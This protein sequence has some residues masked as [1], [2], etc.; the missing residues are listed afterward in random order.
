VTTPSQ[1]FVYEYDPA[2]SW[3]FHVELIGV[4]KDE[5]PRITYPHCMRR[6]GIGPAQY[7]LHAILPDKL[8][9][10]EEQYDLGA[11]EMAEGF[12]SEGEEGADAGEGDI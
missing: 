10:E 6:E 2:K 8:M 7:D 9:E 3:T 12:S 4:S 5:N 1:K 11:D